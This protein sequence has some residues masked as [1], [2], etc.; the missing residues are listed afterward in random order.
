M[1]HR[2][3]GVVGQHH[4]RQATIQAGIKEGRKEWGNRDWVLGVRRWAEEGLEIQ[5]HGCAGTRLPAV[6]VTPVPLYGSHPSPCPP[7]PPPENPFP[8]ATG[9]IS[10][11][12]AL[13]LPLLTL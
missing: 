12:P 2:S 7:P 6:W 4:C 5:V 3:R 1:R 9:G 11:A 10:W 13:P 8:K